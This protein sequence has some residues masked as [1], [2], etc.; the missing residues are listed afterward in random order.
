MQDKNRPGVI[1]SD[2]EHVIKIRWNDFEELENVLSQG[3]NDIA[4]FIYYPMTI[5]FLEIIHYQKMVT[6]KSNFFM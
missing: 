6:G 2:S 5:R 4:C 3:N 1:A